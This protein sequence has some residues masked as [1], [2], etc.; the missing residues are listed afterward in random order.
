MPMLQTECP[1][2]AGQITAQDV[3]V[4]EII[5]CRDCGAELEV[6]AT[7]PFTLELAPAVQEDWGE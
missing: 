2:C 5:P 4:G 7:E 6:R 3:L 1:V